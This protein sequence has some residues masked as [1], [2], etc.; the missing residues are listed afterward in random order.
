MMDLRAIPQRNSHYHTVHGD[1]VAVAVGLVEQG[2]VVEC[3]TRNFGER[4]FRLNKL[5]REALLAEWISRGQP[6][7]NELD[8]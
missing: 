6:K 2:L 1:N 5:G 4:H 7:R 8:G 3:D